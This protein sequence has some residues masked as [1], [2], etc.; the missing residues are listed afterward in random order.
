MTQVD[1]NLRSYQ[2]FLASQ[3]ESRKHTSYFQVYDELFGKYV[4]QEITFVEVGVLNGGSLFMWRHF[5]GPKARIIGVELNPLAKKWEQDGFE[6]Y[7]GSQA[8]PAFWEDLFKKIGK[9]DVLLDDGGHFND[10]QIITTLAAIPHVKDG[11]MVV[12]EDAHASYMRQF[13]NPSKYSFMNFC[14][15]TVDRINARFP[16]INNA[17]NLFSETVFSIA[18]YESIVAFKIDRTKCFNSQPI[19]NSGV[20]SMAKD[21]RKIDQLQRVSFFER[22]IYRNVVKIARSANKYALSSC[23]IGIPLNNFLNRKL[24]RFFK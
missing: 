3:Y 21:F 5:F 4:D 14:Y 24:R 22:T 15:K 12:V 10:Q 13:T 7:I 8:D 9:V 18:F 20:S 16:E 23:L 19:K 17:K 6:I 1:S 2:G 11:G